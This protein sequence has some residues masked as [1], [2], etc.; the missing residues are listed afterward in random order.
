MALL[1]VAE[2]QAR[3][4]D[5]VAPLPVEMVALDQA[6]GRVLAA[7]LLARRTQPPADVSAMDG[8]AVRASDATAGARLRVIGEAAAG[9]PFAGGLAAGQ[10][11]RIFTGAVIPGGA[12][13][14]VIQEDTSASG[15]VVT[16]HEAA[17]KGRHIRAAGLDFAAGRLLLPAG[18]RLT[19]AALALAAA[20]NHAELPVHRRP[21][22]AIFSTGDE[23]VAPGGTPDDSQIVSSNALAL[24][25]AARRAGADAVDLGIVPDTLAATVEAIR[26]ARAIGAEILV[27]TGGASVGDYDLVQ[28]ALKAE[29]LTLDFW[30]L[31]LRP[32]KPFMFGRLG[33]ARVLGLPGNPVSCFVCGVLFLSPLIARLQGVADALPAFEPATLGRDLPANDHREEFMRARLTLDGGRLVA[34]PFTAQDSSL[35]SVLA[36]AQCLV[37]RPAHAPAMTG[38]A[39]VDILRL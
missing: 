11:V 27:T 16:L 30:K 28:P 9:R 12:D 10:A 29:G 19:P 1:P 39:T 5:G 37:R 15:D 38:G 21:K 6:D 34:T 3:I 32:G 26:R 23:L 31:A 4:L 7:D 35:V 33:E 13:A 2:A 8:Y 24:T 20:A 14:V 25:L 36:Q 22:V 18:T 17:R